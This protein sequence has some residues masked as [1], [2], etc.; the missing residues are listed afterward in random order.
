MNRISAIKDEG[1]KDNMH[2][3]IRSLVSHI[4]LIA[5]FHLMKLITI[6]ID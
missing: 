2:L 4:G 1:N 5:D 3:A 6:H